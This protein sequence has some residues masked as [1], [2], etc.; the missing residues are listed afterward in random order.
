MIPV[1]P[2]S[3]TP[4]AAI[5]TVLAEPGPEGP[6]AFGEEP[7]SVPPTVGDAEPDGEG[8]IEPVPVGVGLPV[9]WEVGELEGFGFPTTTTRPHIPQF[10]N[11][12]SLPW[13]W[14]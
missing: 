2:S 12:V 4:T 13:I 7:E 14:Q 6:D 8:E 10:G 1:P 5:A 11:A 3:A 9:P